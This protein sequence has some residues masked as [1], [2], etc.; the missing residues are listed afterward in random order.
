MWRSRTPRNG[1]WHEGVRWGR[2]RQWGQA[3]LQRVALAHACVLL[4]LLSFGCQRGGEETTPEPV[5]VAP[6]R[7][8]TSLTPPD[9]TWVLALEPQHLLTEPLWAGIM[10]VAFPVTQRQAF[11]RLFVVRAE[12]VREA[13]L[14]RWHEAGFLTL[15]R[16]DFS[17]RD[18][19]NGLGMRMNTVEVTRED[20]ARRV[21][22][23]GTSRRE[24]LQLDDATFAYSGDA[25][26]AMAHVANDAAGPAPQTESERSRLEALLGPAPVRY[27]RLVP[28]AP[29]PES[30]LYLVLARQRAAGVALRAVPGQSD[31]LEL[32]L[33]L[34]GEFPSTIE[35][36]ARTVLTQLMGSDL[37]HAL[38]GRELPPLALEI[39][40]Q[41][42]HARV[43]LRASTLHA[44]L[45]T[46]FTDGLADL[47]AAP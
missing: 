16:G 5:V 22:F 40:E 27:L 2:G 38:L 4:G 47:F 33:V 29:P 8:L 44:G 6:T 9:A 34:T 1:T 43:Q 12:E 42:L 35:D 46:V 31:L 11:E 20:P 45:R 36:N 3:S 25:G 28:M 13:T 23:L 24:A 26:P 17:G 39:G 41:S 19:V 18:V 32:H 14:V 7:V 10:E 21:G 30:P 15:L 37:G